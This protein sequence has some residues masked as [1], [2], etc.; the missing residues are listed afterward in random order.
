[1]RSWTWILVNN[2]LSQKIPS[3]QSVIYPCPLINLNLSLLTFTL[4]AEYNDRLGAYG[5]SNRSLSLG[6]LDFRGSFIN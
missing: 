4:S 6:P 3:Y 5:T 2:L 1:M